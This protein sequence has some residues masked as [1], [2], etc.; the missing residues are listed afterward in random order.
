MWKEYSRAYVKNNRASALSVMSA[1]FISALFLSLLCGLFYNLWK[2]DVERINRETGDWES[3][4]AGQMDQ[5]DILWIES[6]ASIREA[7]V[8]E[9]ES[10]GGDMTV[11]LYFRQRKDV[12]TDTPQI[13]E[14]LGIASDK[15]SYNFPL[16]ALYGIRSE[17]DPA[18][19]LALP[20]FA[21]TMAL[22]ALSLIVI[23][24]NAFAVSMNARI[25][26]FGIFSSIGAAPGQI[27]RC[28]LQEAGGLCAL[29]VVLGNLLGIGMSFGMIQLINGLAGGEET[30]RHNAV[31]G[32]HPLVLAAALAVTL[33][34]VWISAWIPAWKLSRIT[35][36]EAIKNTGELQLKRKKSSPVLS[37]LFG[38]EGELAGCALRAQR[39]ALRTA[40]LSLLLSF[41]AFTLMQ[42]FFT[43]SAI[44]TRETYFERYQDAW[45]IMITIKDTRAD[46]VL[47]RKQIQELSGVESAAV[48]QKAMVRRVL[49]DAELSGEMKALGGFSQAAAG[50]AEKTEGGW[51]VKAPVIVL[52][53]A[54]F[55]DYCRQT[56][57]PLRLDGAV[58]W[59]QIRDVNNPDFRHPQYVPYIE[60]GGP[61]SLLPLE[62]GGLGT[63]GLGTEE[64][65][66]E[67]NAADG[68]GI[69]RLEAG[70]GAVEIPVL[71]CTEKLPLLRE[72][73]AKVNVYELV[74][75]VPVS[76]WK[77][78]RGVLGGEEEDSFIRILGQG[79]PSLEELERLQ[80]EIG[81][82]LGKKYVIE[83]ENR[84]Q[85]SQVNDRQIW[86][87]M[88]VLGG[89]CVIL[90][91]IGI[92]SALSN[93]LGFVRQR[94]RE[95]ARYLSVGMTPGQ[96]KKMFC[97]E[98]IVLALRPVLITLPLA[99]A[100]VWYML[101]ISYMDAGTFLAQAP[102]LPVAVFMLM[103][104]GGVA[105]AYY[106]GWRGLGKINLAEALRDDTLL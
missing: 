71:A 73:F 32:Y 28:L 20:F 91:L 22:A 7:V 100:A 38:V 86:G 104:W 87:M 72:E 51:L 84:I 48:Y 11:D 83:S 10:G 36:L 3:R 19:R 97:I 44:S 1:A 31:F 94:R 92:G 54:S 74:H 39:K 60:E 49:G 24:H 46:D 47:E 76:L 102:F 34:T 77:E 40:S 105:L 13:A 106:L 79:E 23:I 52:D 43:L 53:D 98:G 33:A 90:A 14:Y 25:H 58:V 16:L 37:R 101:R 80:E 35:P 29:P 21:L 93:T 89:F 56:G 68:V 99:A 50:E 15:V 45:D 18:P 42:C 41:M 6:F 62:E 78:I 27:R 64:I 70:M 17:Q 96:V 82:L 30:G 66:T 75:I 57:A 8:N 88:A 95:I 4:I 65:G 63:E 67:G 81:A 69:R 9:K 61:A 12:L 55:L 103:V 59:N 5:G 26:Q 85:E 2:Y